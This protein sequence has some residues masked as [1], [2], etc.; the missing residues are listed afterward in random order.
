MST[1]HGRPESI[2][3]ASFTCF[4]TASIN[5]TVFGDHC[6]RCSDALILKAATFVSTIS[7]SIKTLAVDL[8]LSRIRGTGRARHYQSAPNS[9]VVAG[10][11]S[12]P[13]ALSDKTMEMSSRGNPRLHRRDRRRLGIEIAQILPAQGL[14]SKAEQLFAGNVPGQ[15]AIGGPPLFSPLSPARKHVSSSTL[16]KS[17]QNA[18]FRLSM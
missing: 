5:S 3:P 11:I 13:A 17:E 4:T 7:E 18:A 10:D 9:E 12:L 15:R 6:Q 2:P 1:T 14:N 16:A 8:A